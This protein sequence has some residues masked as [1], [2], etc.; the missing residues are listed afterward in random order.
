MLERTLQRQ[1]KKECHRTCEQGIKLCS[2]ISG[3]L[4]G[5]LE[6]PCAGIFNGLT[7]VASGGDKGRSDGDDQGEDKEGADHGDRFERQTD[8]FEK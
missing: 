6:E 7:T 2:I 3:R 1:K 8:C 4:D 5:S